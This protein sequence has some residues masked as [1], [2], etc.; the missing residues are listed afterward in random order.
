MSIAGRCIA[1][2]TASGM[3]VGP[4]MQRNSR[5]LATVMLVLSPGEDLATPLRISRTTARRQAERP[6]GVGARS[7]TRCPG[8][9]LRPVEHSLIAADLERAILHPDLRLVDLAVV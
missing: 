4:G 1:A 6:E 7:S 2:S 8:P 3:L 5:P 9:G